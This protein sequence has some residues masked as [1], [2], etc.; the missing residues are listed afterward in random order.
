MQR[1]A[2]LTSPSAA[3]SAATPAKAQAA[4]TAKC[5][6]LYAPPA[7]K[8]PGYPS[9]PGKTAPFIAAS[10]SPACG[11]VNPPP[12]QKKNVPGLSPGTFHFA[13]MA[14]GG[15]G[16]CPKNPQGHRPLTLPGDTVPWT[17]SFLGDLLGQVVF[18]PL[19]GC[20]ADV[21]YT[22]FVQGAA[23]AGRVGQVYKGFGTAHAYKGH[24]G[25]PGCF[26]VF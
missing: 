5:L 17:P 11:K 26:G 22:A 3:R 24:I 6:R 14:S 21:F 10:A 20:L 18:C 16:L 15:L 12:Q 19:E 2:L 25:F 23:Q 9:S 4:P 13:R 7:A 8:R 1:K